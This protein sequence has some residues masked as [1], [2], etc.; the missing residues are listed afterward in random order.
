MRTLFARVERSSRTAQRLA[1]RLERLPNLVVRYPG[2]ASHPQ[3]A[4]AAKQMQRGFGSVLSLQV[5][6]GAAGA[7]GVIER[8]RVW[9]PATSLGGV[10]SLIEHR[11]SVEG[12]TTPTP[13]DLLRLS[14]GLEHEEDLYDDL[15]QALAGR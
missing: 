9:V 3:H 15:V 12:P 4:I 11:A 14:V 7:L 6:G 5:G 2:L 1:E 8:L 10:E 13:A